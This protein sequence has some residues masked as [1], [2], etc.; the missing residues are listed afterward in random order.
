MV[1]GPN[2]TW[3]LTCALALFYGLAPWLRALISR[4][5]V[6]PGL[7]GRWFGRCLHA[8]LVLRGAGRVPCAA[9]PASLGGPT[10]AS[11]YTS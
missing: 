11:P 2:R 1:G 6:P 8:A 3:D 7:G 9:R 4:N 5:P 10:G